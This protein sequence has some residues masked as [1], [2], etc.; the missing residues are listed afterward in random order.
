MGVETGDGILQMIL[1]YSF[2]MS[3]MRNSSD[4]SLSTTM[5]NFQK[6]NPLTTI[7]RPP[8]PLYLPLFSSLFPKQ[9]INVSPSP[10]PN[11]IPKTMLDRRAV[12]PV[13]EWTV[14]SRGRKRAKPVKAAT[15]VVRVSVSLPPRCDCLPLAAV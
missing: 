3:T 7:V 4:F 12:D 15:D 1:D 13:G 9:N 11:Y 2:P 5:N 6:T 10:S 8:P 14:V